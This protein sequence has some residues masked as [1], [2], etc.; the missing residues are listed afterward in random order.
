MTETEAVSSSKL[1]NVNSC[2]C[3]QARRTANRRKTMKSTWQTKAWKQAVQEF[4]KGKKCEWCGSTEGLLAHHPYQDTK[5]GIYPNLYLSGCI[6][7]CSTCH[8]MYH[9]RHKKRCP[10]C[11]TGW[12]HLDTDMCYECWKKANPDV[13]REREQFAL[14]E[15]ANRKAL[16]DQR[17]A[18]L[19]AAKRRH[20]CTFRTVTGKCTKSSFGARCPYAA[21]KAMEHCDEAIAKKGYLRAEA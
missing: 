20:P 11:G 17:N 13:V 15:K 1:T 6:V 3:P 18:R 9:R 7:L 8:F 4:V 10:V 16:N 2:T 19:R 5:D 14:L 21:T 12:R